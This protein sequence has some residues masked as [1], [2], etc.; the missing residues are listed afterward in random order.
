MFNDLTPFPSHNGFDVEINLEQK[1]AI[2]SLPSAS[3][4]FFSDSFYFY[5]NLS[6]LQRL[7]PHGAQ[8]LA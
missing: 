2:S 6:F 8:G 5:N 4:Y 1:S 7:L 3:L